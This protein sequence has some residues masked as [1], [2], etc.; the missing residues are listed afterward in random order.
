VGVDAR[1]GVAMH[2]FALNVSTDLSSFEMIVP[3]GH[4]APVTSVEDF[5]GPGVVPNLPDLA[6]QLVPGLAR[7]FDQIPLEVDEERLLDSAHH[8]GRKP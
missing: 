6:R 2:G 3:C 4:A 1:G 8:H 5:T 7:R